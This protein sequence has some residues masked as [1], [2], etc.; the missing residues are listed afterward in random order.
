MTSFMVESVGINLNMIKNK[1]LN[2]A[3]LSLYTIAA[4]AATAAALQ[5]WFYYSS[6][7]NQDSCTPSCFFQTDKIGISEKEPGEVPL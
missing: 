2:P 7:W 4:T 1:Q 6:I 3:P 5:R